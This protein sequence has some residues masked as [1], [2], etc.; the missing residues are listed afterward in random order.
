MKRAK[1][2]MT[3]TVIGIIAAGEVAAKAKS[4]R[5]LGDLFYC[6]G[7]PLTCQ[8]SPIYSND[9]GISTGLPTSIFF[10]GSGPTC[11]SPTLGCNNTHPM[12]VLH[13]PM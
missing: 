7:T 12:I 6:A 9:I 11:T 1:L 10:T 13:A 5:G 2:F 3:G 4:V 8:P